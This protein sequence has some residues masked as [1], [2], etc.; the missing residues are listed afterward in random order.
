MPMRAFDKWGTSPRVT[1]IWYISL[2]LFSLA[3]L[4]IIPPSN[5]SYHFL[6]LKTKPP[7][8]CL[9]LG[10][11]K[12]VNRFCMLTLCY[13]YN[14]TIYFLIALR[15]SKCSFNVS[16]PVS[17][18]L[19]IPISFSIISSARSLIVCINCFFLACN[20]ANAK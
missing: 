4:A 19:S 14:F 11:R 1:L 17:F 13:V 10:E 12:E 5:T 9:F 18:H 7:S 3:T 2:L 6:T 15:N 20:M 16:S 8:P